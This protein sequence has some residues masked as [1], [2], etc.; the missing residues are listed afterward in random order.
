MSKVATNNVGGFTA[1]EWDLIGVALS[2]Y[3]TEGRANGYASH[4]EATEAQ[5]LLFRVLNARD[6]AREGGE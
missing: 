4:E 5:A 1:D 2:V 3:V 6:T